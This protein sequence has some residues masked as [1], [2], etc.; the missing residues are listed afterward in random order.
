M[1]TENAIPPEWTADLPE[2]ARALGPPAAAA[3]V[4]PALARQ[5]LRAGLPRLRLGLLL[6]AVP[7]LALLLAPSFEDLRHSV[8]FVVAELAFAFGVAL[9]VT[10]I[11]PALWARRQRGLHILV[12]PE[13]LVR[14]RGRKTTVLRWDEAALHVRL[15]QPPPLGEGYTRDNLPDCA[16]AFS[17]RRADGVE[18]RVDPVLPGVPELG[19][20]CH[21][22]RVKRLLPHARERL[23]A[24]EAVPFG[25]LRISSQGVGTVAT[26]VPWEE[27]EAISIRLARGMRGSL[28]VERRGAPGR[29]LRIDDIA[30]IPDLPVF[31]VLADEVRGKA[32]P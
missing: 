17:L 23:A 13:G 29:S 10:G 32:P 22:Q 3:G 18:I 25:P 20:I 2:A 15:L 21:T 7:P 26:T 14:C 5:V 4:D 1:T 31:L 12:C 27:V 9:V 19:R 16:A 28:H 6:L 8:V 11:L 24:G 30:S